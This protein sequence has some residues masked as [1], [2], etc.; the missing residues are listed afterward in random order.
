MPY[1]SSS[2]QI[3]LSSLDKRIFLDVLVSGFYNSEKE[4]IFTFHLS[5]LKKK[6]LEKFLRLQ[7]ELEIEPGF[8]PKYVNPQ[9]LSFLSSVVPPHTYKQGVYKMRNDYV[10][11]ERLTTVTMKQFSFEEIKIVCVLATCRCQRLCFTGHESQ[12]TPFYNVFYI[13]ADSSIQLI[14]VQ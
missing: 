1:F 6:E 11:V 13:Q 12:R 9:P 5:L 10:S 4:I 7:T 2:C 3:L 8:E 14:Y